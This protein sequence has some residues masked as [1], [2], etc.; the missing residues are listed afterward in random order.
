M[1]NSVN[2]CIS[3][4]L[5]EHAR[6]TESKINIFGIKKK[7]IVFVVTFYLGFVQT[8]INISYL[9]KTIA[10]KLHYEVEL[11]YITSLSLM[12]A[13]YSIFILPIASKALQNY[14]TLSVLKTMSF[15]TA[16][17][18]LI[19]YYGFINKNYVVTFIGQCILRVGMGSYLCFTKIKY[20]W[21]G[22]YKDSAVYVHTLQNHLMPIF[23]I[24]CLAGMIDDLHRYMTTITL[25]S[26]STFPLC[27]LGLQFDDCNEDSDVRLETLRHQFKRTVTSK[28]NLLFSVYKMILYVQSKTFPVLF[29]TLLCAYGYD[30]AI[31]KIYTKYVGMALLIANVLST[32]SAHLATKREHSRIL[33]CYL[34]ILGFVGIIS[35]LFYVIV[36]PLYRIRMKV[37]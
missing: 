28:N 18:S 29:S 14:G 5:I 4:F 2:S 8:L 25:F 15:F 21:F 13:V 16:V 24:V 20:S 10:L 7:Y 27:I 31:E 1:S 12:S 30:N 22:G 32:L 11:Y 34:K 37:M 35:L 19:V 23:L 6:I 33:H 17:G 26:V 3:S 9:Y 36:M